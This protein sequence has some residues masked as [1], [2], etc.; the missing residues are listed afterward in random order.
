MAR[1]GRLSRRDF[2]TTAAV[3]TGSS[4][5][6]KSGLGISVADSIQISTSQ[7]KESPNREKTTWKV[8]PFPLKQ[9]R[10]GEGPCKAAMEADRQYLR[11]LPTDRLL[12]TF[13]VNAGIGSSAQPLGGWEAP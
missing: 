13:R 12:H 7:Q 11:S 2:M 3:V 5:L 10:L 6:S 8:H 4:L 1:F 9:V